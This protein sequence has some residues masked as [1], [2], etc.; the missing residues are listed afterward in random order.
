MFSLKQGSNYYLMT[1]FFIFSN[2]NSEILKIINIKDIFINRKDTVQRP[3]TDAITFGNQCR[4]S[5]PV[6]P[7]VLS[8]SATGGNRPKQYYP[9]PIHHA[10]RRSGAPLIPE[11]GANQVIELLCCSR[12]WSILL[13]TPLLYWFLSVLL[14]SRRCCRLQHGPHSHGVIVRVD[15]RGQSSTIY[16]CTDFLMS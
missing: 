3:A 4:R 5:R 2:Y 12:V 14:P 7:L 6:P 10:R 8:A 1:Q 15:S 13:T 9:H 11:F 16:L